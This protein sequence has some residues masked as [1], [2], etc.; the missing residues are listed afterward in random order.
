[1]ALRGYPAA[2]RQNPAV[3][4]RRSLIAGAAGIS[5]LS[6]APSGWALRGM[7]S[8]ALRE[9]GSLPDPTRPEG[10]VDPSMPFDHV[11]V[12][13]QENH[14]FD[15]YFG[16]LARRGQPLADGYAFGASGMP[17]DAN[18]YKDGHLRVQHAPSLC[19]PGGETQSWRGTHLQID[20]G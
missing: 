12:V 8:M 6:A 11:V 1:M 4:T 9:P 13:M 15:A 2:M 7:G 10:T 16:M 19:Q 14:S 20:R 17:L 3:L 5:A 18:P